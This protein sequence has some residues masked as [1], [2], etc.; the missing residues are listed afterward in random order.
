[1]V[2]R[3]KA[4][5]QQ[6]KVLQTE[7]AETKALATAADAAATAAAATAAE[8][9][10]AAAASTSRHG[11]GHSYLTGSM[12]SERGER[13][14]SGDAGDASEVR[15]PRTQSYMDGRKASLEL[16]SALER[17]NSLA[18]EV[19][20]VLLLV[21]E[22][23]SDH[24]EVRLEGGQEAAAGQAGSVKQCAS[25]SE[26]KKKAAFSA[27][28][29][30]NAKKK[31][32]KC[33]VCTAAASAAGSPAATTEAVGVATAKVGE[34]GEKKAGGIRPKRASTADA[35][36]AAMELQRSLARS[37][38]L[39]G[40]VHEAMRLMEELDLPSNVPSDLPSGGAS[41]GSS[42]GLRR[43]PSI[44]ATGGAGGRGSSGG[45]GGNGG[46]GKGGGGGGGGR[47]ASPSV[48]FAD[49][50]SFDFP[51]PPP[52][53]S[54]SSLPETKEA[55][56]SNEIGN[57][58]NNESS[59][60]AHRNKSSPAAA[61]ELQRSFQRSQSLATE[62]DEAMHLADEI[63]ADTSVSSSPP[64]PNSTTRADQDRYGGDD[65]GEGSIFFHEDGSSPPFLGRRHGS[66][67]AELQRSFRRSQSI[68]AEVHEALDM[69]DDLLTGDCTAS[70]STSPTSGSPLPQSGDGH[71][72][73]RGDG[74]GG[75]DGIGGVEGGEGGASLSFAQ[76]F[77]G[78]DGKTLLTPVGMR[79]VSPTV[80]RANER[81]V[82]LMHSMADLADDSVLHS[83]GVMNHLWGG[84]YRGGGEYSVYDESLKRQGNLFKKGAVRLWGVGDGVEGG[85]GER[86]EGDSG[87]PGG[88]GGPGG[89]GGRGEGEG[90]YSS[91][92][93]EGLL[94]N[95]SVQLSESIEG[96]RESMARHSGFTATQVEAMQSMQVC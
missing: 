69:V 34:K 86:G 41:G 63:L 79:R 53:A 8:L 52:H 11:H 51:P 60:N 57:G 29:W 28:Q 35:R 24:D 82:Q 75:Q 18:L 37:N 49:M 94:G 89:Q 95:T 20:S 30:K 62:V 93:M 58:I 91:Y 61:A 42:G 2:S 78:G 4:L 87:G 43:P 84:E 6:N 13:G 33:K 50:S 71:G 45:G 7:L 48:S 46:G 19:A 83:P 55:T 16:R 15:R 5:Q 1:M 10:A 26:S 70:N 64:T 39:A 67:T 92:A 44:I 9:T 72:G 25:C 12:Y 32:P 66:A 81:S 65:E 96:L 59:S 40:E 17:S 27:N 47:N 56:G 88:P 36:S 14:E 74:G 90:G 85:R 38:S 73:D 76:G 54:S 68:A 31:P 77:V 3:F 22:V 23:E 80:T 21:E